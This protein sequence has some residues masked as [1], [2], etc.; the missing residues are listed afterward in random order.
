MFHRKKVPELRI[1]VLNPAGMTPEDAMFAELLMKYPPRTELAAGDLCQLV[2]VP[3]ELAHEGPY[4]NIWEVRGV[5]SEWQRTLYNIVNRNG[6][7]LDWAM[8]QIAAAV[9]LPKNRYREPWV[10]A[11]AFPHGEWPSSAEWFPE[12]CLH[13][14]V[15]AGAPTP[16]WEP[17][18]DEFSSPF[19]G[20]DPAQVATGI[21]LDLAPD[22]YGDQRPR[23][24]PLVFEEDIFHKTCLLGLEELCMVP[25]ADAAMLHDPLGNYYDRYDHPDWRR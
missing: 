23:T 2:S 18:L 9:E 5:Y 22:I 11:H 4:P 21:V 24:R 3:S 19:R 13:K 8:A 17:I 7:Q 6:G 1:Q 15:L 14:L 12:Y 20:Y 25:T 10:Y 16:A